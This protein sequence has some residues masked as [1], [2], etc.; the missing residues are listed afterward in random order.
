V[1]QNDKNPG[2]FTSTAEKYKEMFS[3]KYADIKKNVSEL[4]VSL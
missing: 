3:R 2:T 4:F 1:E